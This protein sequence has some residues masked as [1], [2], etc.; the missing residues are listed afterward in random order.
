MARSRPP[1]V[2]DHLST[3]QANHLLP[4]DGTVIITIIILLFL[5]L[6]FFSKFGHVRLEIFT[7][8]RQKPLHLY[9]LSR[10]VFWLSYYYARRCNKAVFFFYSVICRVIIGLR[11]YYSRNKTIRMIALL[12]Y[13]ISS[14]LTGAF[15]SHILLDTACYSISSVVMTTLFAYFA[16]Q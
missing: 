13:Y 14:V 11:L 2:V 7:R 10:N 5:L 6:Y 4:T 15:L 12:S 16:R 9:L 3:D 8:N 1:R